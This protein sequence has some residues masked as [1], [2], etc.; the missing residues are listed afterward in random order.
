MRGFGISLLPAILTMTGIVGSRL[1]WIWIVFPK[2]NSFDC[3]MLIYPISLCLAAV[4]NLGAVLAVK[5]GRKLL[6]ES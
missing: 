6:K 5:P 3:I 4:L 2:Y 1:S